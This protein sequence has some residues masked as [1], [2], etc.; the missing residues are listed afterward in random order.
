[1]PP[2]PRRPS[3]TAA[4]A[5]RAMARGKAPLMDRAAAAASTGRSRTCSRRA[6]SVIAASRALPFVVRTR[7]S[8]TTSRTGP[9]SSTAPGR[10]TRWPA[11]V[12]SATRSSSASGRRSHCVAA[13][14]ST[15]LNPEPSPP[16]RRARTPAHVRANSSSSGQRRIAPSM[17]CAVSRS[18]NS[19]TA[20]SP[21]QRASTARAAARG[22]SS[23]FPSSLTRRGA[24]A[25]RS[26]LRCVISFTRPQAR[27]RASS[28]S[29]SSPARTARAAPALRSCSADACGASAP[30]N[31][32]EPPLVGS[33]ARRAHACRAAPPL[34]RSAAPRGCAATTARHRSAASASAASR[35]SGRRTLTPSLEIKAA[36]KA[37]FDTSVAVSLITSRVGWRLNSSR[38]IPA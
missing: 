24:D 36:R 8:A 7:T 9:A 20:S 12:K 2:A 31:K 1:M 32:E 15:S 14:A 37:S 5:A 10:S 28:S 16:E 25:R 29:S 6:R 26:L 38:N 30:N 19:C 34:R 21:A 27:S 13:D 22:L 23:S 3:A 33:S 17:L 35:A 11:S 4:A 18:T